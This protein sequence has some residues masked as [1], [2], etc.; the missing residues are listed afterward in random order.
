[1]GKLICEQTIN[2][3]TVLRS[4]TTAPGTAAALVKTLPGVGKPYWYWNSVPVGVIIAADFT[5][6]PIAT[7]STSANQTA[8]NGIT[9]TPQDVLTYEDPPTP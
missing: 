9:A 7:S 1:M 5:N 6:A 4:V 8:I 3:E 2:G